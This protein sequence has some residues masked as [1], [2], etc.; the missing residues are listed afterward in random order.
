M[1]T[2]DMDDFL[3]GGSGKPP[4]PPHGPRGG[5]FEFQPRKLLAVLTLF[6]ALLVL[7][8]AVRGQLG[9][10]NISHDQVA[11]K[12]N[13]LTGS[14]QVIT[15]PG[16][17]IYV[18]FLEQVFP[19]DRTPQKFLM[20]GNRAQGDNHVPFLTV[21]A[22]DGSNF[23]FESLEIQY[24]IVPG[25]ADKVLEDSG[26]A[27]EFKREWV[28][29]FARSVLRDEFGKY[30]AVEVAD[31]STYQAARI[32]STKRLNDL[33]NPH[34]IDVIDVITPKPRFDV[35]YEQA[36][37]D[38]KVADQDVERLRE[39]EKR[40]INERERRLSG[41]E[42]E[43]SIQMEALLGELARKRLGAEREQIQIQLAADEYAVKRRAEGT[44]E[45]DQKVL[46][47]AG[48]RE[49]YTRE[50]EGLRARAEALEKRGAVVVREALIERLRDIRFTLI[51]YS[52]DPE[53]R[54]LEHVDARPA[55][56][57]LELPAREG[58]F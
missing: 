12:V 50:A 13:Y 2:I 4:R 47:S 26:P 42:K 46:T 31:P 27:E 58:G 10:M 38:R 39:E 24:A 35:E 30:S 34:G 48:L 52:R 5:R 54:R 6:V 7:A 45:R 29:G 56:V 43:K 19:L 9:V 57:R 49:K 32:E 23:W 8:S 28:R 18:P 17:K 21:R 15:T 1:K 53:P 55:Q 3:K 51:P 41:V 20:E 33:L 40:L 37:E 11:V 16:F 25:M 22:S 44:A 14:R 36:I